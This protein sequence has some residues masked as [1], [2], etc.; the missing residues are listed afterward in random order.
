MPA[1]DELDIYE[2]EIVIP[3]WFL[4]ESNPYSKTKSHFLIFIL[5]QSRIYPMGA[6]LKHAGMTNT[7]YACVK[8]VISARF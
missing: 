4:Q 1:G 3:A 8:S 2:K 6:R 5:L 7:L